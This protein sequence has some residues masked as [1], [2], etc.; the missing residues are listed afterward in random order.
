MGSASL[1]TGRPASVA[2]GCSMWQSDI[3]VVNNAEQQPK[4]DR[5]PDRDLM[6]VSYPLLGNCTSVPHKV[7]E[8]VRDDDRPWRWNILFD[9]RAFEGHEVF[10]EWEAFARDWYGLAG[11]RDSGRRMAVVSEDPLIAA[12]FSTHSYQD[13]FPTRDVRLF[14]VLEDAVA[15][16]GADSLP[17]RKH[18]A[19]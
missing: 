15:W 8:D 19:H 13:L 16:A 1:K 11:D 14:T 9:M 5:R 10:A 18:A 7:M 17:A 6:V 12:R 3:R 4:I 2:M